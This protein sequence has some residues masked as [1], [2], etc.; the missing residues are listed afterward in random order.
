MHFDIK[1]AFRQV[2]A[3]TLLGLAGAGAGGYSYHATHGALDAHHTPES[4]AAVKTYEARL[5]VIA[6]KQAALLNTTDEDAASRLAHA[7]RAFIADVILDPVISEADVGDLAESFNTLSADDHVAFRFAQQNPKS[8][9]ERNEALNDV[10]LTK[11]RMETAE[12]TQ[13]CMLAYAVKDH[14]GT[15]TATETGALLGVG[16]AASFF[17]GQFIGRRRA[18]KP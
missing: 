14:Q 10:A 15:Q 9:S 3:V 5:D 8:V 11:D 17:L 18:R 4:I 13:D 6:N 16:F 12:R 2:A 1:K 7:K